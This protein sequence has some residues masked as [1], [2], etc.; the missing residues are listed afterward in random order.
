MPPEARG[1]DQSVCTSMTS[2]LTS[3]GHPGGDT[4][5]GAERP[6]A[7]G[8]AEQASLFGDGPRRCSPGQKWSWWPTCASS[9]TCCA[10]ATR[11]TSG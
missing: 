4:I 10:S 1:R 8:L 7:L 2:Q 6:L 11:S 3:R 5:G 9:T